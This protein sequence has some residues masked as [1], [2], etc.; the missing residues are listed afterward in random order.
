LHDFSG[1]PCVRSCVHVPE[2]MFKKSHQVHILQKNASFVL[3]ILIEAATRLLTDNLKISG[4]IPPDVDSFSQSL[5]EEM[6]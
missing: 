2:S 3:I 4:S 5:H 6:T 1:N